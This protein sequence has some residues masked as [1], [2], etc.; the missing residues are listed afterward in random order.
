MHGIRRHGT[1]IGSTTGCMTSSGCTWWV[2]DGTRT[3]AYGLTALYDVRPAP[4]QADRILAAM[5]EMP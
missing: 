2:A 5:D 4:Q 1:A 3:H